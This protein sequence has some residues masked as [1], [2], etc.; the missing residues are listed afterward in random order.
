MVTIPNSIP[1]HLLLL[2]LI[3]PVHSCLLSV[4]GSK[5]GLA[6]EN[7]MITITATS[8]SGDADRCMRSNIIN[9]RII[10]VDQD[11]EMLLSPDVC[12]CVPLRGM[13]QCNFPAAFKPLCAGR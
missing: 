13:N 7:V 1:I 8:D 3:I 11:I 10:E 9:T 5:R 4:S 2:S 12:L 6:F